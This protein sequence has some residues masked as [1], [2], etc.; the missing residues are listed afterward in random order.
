MSAILPNI[1]GDII[2]RGYNCKVRIGTSPTDAQTIA[3][4][5]SFQANVDFQVQEAVCI[6]YLGPVSLDPQGYTCSITMSGF[7]PSKRVLSDNIQYAEGGSV[8]IMEYLPS[9]ED[10]MG[11]GKIRKIAY[12]EFYNDHPKA[13]VALAAFEGV[14]V[15]SEGITAEGNQYVRNNVQMRALRHI[16]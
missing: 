5:A 13:G 14:I 3:M 11:G 1:T 2:A 7:V 9:W 16:K 10:F 6:G 15:T 4:V 12:L 8:S